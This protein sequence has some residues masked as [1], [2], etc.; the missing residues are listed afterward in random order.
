ML[1]VLVLVLVLLRARSRA[2]DSTRE[3]EATDWWKDL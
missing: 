2:F 1:R 3:K